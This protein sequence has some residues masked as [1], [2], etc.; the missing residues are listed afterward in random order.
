MAFLKKITGGDEELQAY[1]QRMAGYCLTGLV[2]EHV[3]F[4]LYG[5]GANGK[6]VFINTLVEIMGDYAL[7]IGTEMLMVSNSD[8]HPTEVARLRGVRLAVG[9]EIEIG[10][11][12]A[13]SKIKRV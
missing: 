1:L 10:K 3:L 11:T 4:F 12:W 6:S 5:T 8:R 9:N 2:S 7:T 13:E